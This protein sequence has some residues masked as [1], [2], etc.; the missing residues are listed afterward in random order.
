MEWIR[1]LYDIEDRAREYSID[2]RREVRDRE[3][4]P[5]LDK[6]EAYLAEVCVFVRT[7]RS[8]A[9]FCCAGNVGCLAFLLLG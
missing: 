4:N 2:R 5:I 9:G 7:N 6:I 1:Q 8:A 3:A